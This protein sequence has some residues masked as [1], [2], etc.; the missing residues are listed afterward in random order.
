MKANN[1]YLL[2]QTVRFLSIDNI[3]K[4]DDL[5]R[6][7]YSTAYDHNGFALGFKPDDWVGQAWHTIE[8]DLPG[9]IGKTYREYMNWDE[10]TEYIMHEICRRQ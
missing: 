10:P 5:I 8:D 6:H 4:P 7:R 1:I 3:L 9:W 2:D